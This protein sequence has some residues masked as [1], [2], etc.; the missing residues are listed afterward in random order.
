M[1]HA[2]IIGG[3]GQIARKMT[4][5]LVSKGYQVSSLY[6]HD[7][8]HQ[9]LADLGA[10]PVKGDLMKLGVSDLQTQI[11]H[12]DIVV[13]AAG[14]GGAGAD[15][16]RAID[17]EGLEKAVSAAKAAGVQRFYLISVFPE[18]GRT[19]DL[20]DGFE[21]YMQVKKMADVHLVASGLDFAILRPGTLADDTPTGKVSAG[22]AVPY[23]T[24]ARGDVAAFL[25]ELINQPNVIN[26]IIELSPGDTPIT[27][28]VSQLAPKAV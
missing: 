25:A 22:L 16:T 19:A 15:L 8:Q 5:D 6:R 1:A 10:T 20:G 23:G 26:T 3:A 2:F 4:P 24:I 21:V 18:A 27:Q 13:F 7:E 17:G 9:Q 28:A 12:C 11:A 14:A